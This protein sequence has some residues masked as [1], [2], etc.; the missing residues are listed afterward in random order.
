M[1]ATVHDGASRHLRKSPGILA[2]VAEGTRTPTDFGAYLLGRMSTKG[3]QRQVD[4]ARAAGVGDATISRLIYSS[5]FTPDVRTLERIAEALGVPATDLVARRMGDLQPPKVL[6]PVLVELAAMLD[7]ESP[8]P[9]E[10]RRRLESMLELLADANR[11]AMLRKR[12]A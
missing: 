5:E 1:K 11:G 7:P 6:P 2:D 9:A 12:T 3:M 4:L 8:L 10:D